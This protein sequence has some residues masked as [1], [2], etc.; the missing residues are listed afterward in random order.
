[1]PLSAGE[2]ADLNTLAIT[3]GIKSHRYNDV[4]LG[5]VQQ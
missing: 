4:H 2:I 5:Y 1:V 3:T